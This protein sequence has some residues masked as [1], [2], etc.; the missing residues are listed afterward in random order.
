[1]APPISSAISGNP[2]DDDDSPAGL[3]S[4]RRFD[5]PHFALS[6][7]RPD[8]D[9][10]RI[11]FSL[12]NY[13][14]ALTAVFYPAASFSSGRLPVIAVGSEMETR[15]YLPA[16][17]SGVFVEPVNYQP[18]IVLGQNQYGFDDS[19]VRHELVHYAM[20]FSLKR[21]VPLWYGEGMAS[22]FETLACDRAGSRLLVGR[23]SMFRV[24]VLRE[25]GLLLPVEKLVSGGL[26]GMI[27]TVP[28]RFYA[29]SWLLTHA[30]IHDAPDVLAAYEHS[31]LAGKSSSEAWLAAA[32]AAFRGA[33]DQQLTRYLREGRYERGGRL[34]WSAPEFEVST[35][36]LGLGDALAVRALLNLVGARLQPSRAG[37]HNGRA[38][39]HAEAALAHDPTNLTA[40]QVKLSEH[41][42]VAVADLR[43]VVHLSELRWEA[44]LTLHDALETDD[45]ARDERTQALARAA[46]LA[47]D[48]P[49]ILIRLA[50]QALNR[51]LWQDAIRWFSRA[52]VVSPDHPQLARVYLMALS[53][54]EPC[55][56]MVPASAVR[57]DPQALST[58]EQERLIRSVELCV[59]SS[60]SPIGQSANTT[61]QSRSRGS[62]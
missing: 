49:Q 42:P 34:A 50:Y 54:H 35:Q 20:R 38:L 56:A 37:Y 31:L 24:S 25:A 17:M 2:L 12:E 48:D 41:G 7:D 62:R 40:M 61:G 33:M 26:D 8:P 36:P 43:R 44:W 57:M 52:W 4:W 28:D 46:T 60:A 27:E 11:L 39:D 5:S 22:Y 32:P 16:R 30:L 47:P 6:T 55:G 14:A 59:S 3:R 15:R 23:A 9:A 45:S 13:F 1:M 10:R 53:H 21:F 51:R 29:T 58:G 18:L 19:I